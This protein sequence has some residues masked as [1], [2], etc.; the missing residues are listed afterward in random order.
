[1]SGDMASPRSSPVARGRVPLALQL[2][3]AATVHSSMRDFER[4]CAS[5]HCVAT[6]VGVI[7][8]FLDLSK[9]ILFCSI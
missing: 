4:V 1:M 9:T 6:V 2:A 3:R 5:L 7:N 8:L